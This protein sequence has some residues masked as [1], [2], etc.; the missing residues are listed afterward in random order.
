MLGMMRW[1][2]D[3]VNNRINWQY[4]KDCT[5]APYLLDPGFETCRVASSVPPGLGGGTATG[6][7]SGL[8]DDTRRQKKAKYNKPTWSYQYADPGT[9]LVPLA[10]L[11]LANANCVWQ[12]FVEQVSAY[13]VAKVSDITG[14]DPAMIVKV[15]DAYTS[16][17]LDDQSACIM[18]AMGSTQHTYGSQNVRSYA[19]MQ[20]LLG[21]AGVAGGG[22][23]ALRGESNVQGSTD[24]CLLWHILPGYLSVTNNSWAKRDRAAYKATYSSGRAPQ[25]ITPIAG[26]PGYTTGNP[27]SLS[28]WQFGGKYIDSLLQAWWPLENPVDPQVNLDKAYG[29]LPKAK[30]GFWYTHE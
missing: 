15:Y 6:I 5:N 28:W 30:S 2:M 3:P 17:Y 24:M 9:K 1:A 19:M 13:T 26:V 21:N 23:N 18:Y 12:K 29:Y 22:I 16:T 10:D 7:F 8:V 20:L 14:A 4:V 11:T 25:D 27:R